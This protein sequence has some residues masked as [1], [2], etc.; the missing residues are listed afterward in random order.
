MEPIQI[1]FLAYARAFIIDRKFMLDGLTLLSRVIDLPTST[2]DRID[3]QNILTPSPHAIKQDCRD[4]VYLKV[5]DQSGQTE[6]DQERQTLSSQTT[7]K[8]YSGQT[9]NFQTRER[10]RQAYVL[11]LGPLSMD[12]C[13][14]HRIESQ[15]HRDALEVALSPTIS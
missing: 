7:T 14:N 13:I 6:F 15:Y 9:V 3:F 8:F 11:D 10:N 12:I 5:W 2:R 4:L 1:S